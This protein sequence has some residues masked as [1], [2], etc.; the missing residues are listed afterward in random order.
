MA[1]NIGLHVQGLSASMSKLESR[2]EAMQTRQDLL[3]KR[4]Q[5]L[6]EADYY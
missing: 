6:Q 3:E 2:L 5:I 4:V 1:A